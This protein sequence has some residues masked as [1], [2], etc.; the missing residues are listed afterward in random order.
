MTAIS[1]QLFLGKAE[2]LRMVVESFLLYLHKI[3]NY[4]IL[5]LLWLF[6]LCEERAVIRQ[7]GES[8]MEKKEWR[9]LAAL[10]VVILCL[11]FLSCIPFSG[12]T[13]ISTGQDVRAEQGW[14]AHREE[15]Q[16][17]R[18]EKESEAEEG[19]GEKKETGLEVSGFEEDVKKAKEAE[20]TTLEQKEKNYIKLPKKNTKKSRE[21]YLQEHYMASQIILD[22][23]GA[24]PGSYKYSDIKRKFLGKSYSGKLKQEELLKNLEIKQV[25][26]KGKTKLRLIFTFQNIFEPVLY[27]TG[28]AYYVTLKEPDKVYDKIVVVDAG[29]GG[30]DEG[31]SSWDKKDDEK[32]YS[33]T[34]VKHLVKK[35]REHFKG[36]KVRVYCTRTTDMNL[37]K[38]S[39]VT[40][41][42]KLHAD[43]F[44]SIHCNASEAGE[45][46]IS[47]METLYANVPLKYGSLT[48]KR[49]AQIML[50]ELSAVTGREKRGIID[51]EGLYILRNSK[52]PAT[53][54]EVGYMTNPS[55]M[56]FMK[57]EEGHEKIVKG[58]Y[59]GIIKALRYG[60]H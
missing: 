53:I 27:E 51:R 4:Y 6:G 33:L 40:F 10:S 21:V 9:I 52:V 19:T 20:W 49:L 7:S 25:R 16:E 44:V 24:S 13:G 32:T 58:L 59:Q 47:G 37:S 29:H 11:V 22:I 56:E 54:V 17:N 43:L 36:K 48:G 34:T 46:Y 2:Q 60:S 57:S 41:A 15:T 31:T 45:H 1:K 14:K 35:L 8:G 3:L 38:Y 5:D 23:D 28:N 30:M 18:E 55:D 42:N 12:Q 26:G 50:D 39:R